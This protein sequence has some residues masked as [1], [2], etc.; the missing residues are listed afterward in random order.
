MFVRLTRFQCAPDRIDELVDRFQRTAMPTFGE[1]QGF[2]GAIVLADRGT[3]AGE[4]VSY[5]DSAESMQA[6][7]ET[8]VSLRS[9]AAQEQED[10]QIGDIDHLE[11]VVQERV[12]PP[13]AGAFIRVN[14]LQGS[15]SKV[16]DVAK[17]VQESV[18]T[19]KP[20][21]G[22]RSVV[23]AANRETGRMIIS[24]S[25]DSAADREASDAAV[26]ERRQAAVEAAGAQTV[27][28]E[29]YEG[30]FAELKQP[31]VA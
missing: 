20:L 18:S 26:R 21:Q 24:S 28:V 19:L 1:L 31:A 29:L 12:A 6:S 7:E 30:L 27:S 22:F 5:W 2:M 15:P 16:G 9:Q 23:M 8:G 14:D 11:L 3:G 10:L 13:R 4:A 25:W 17:I